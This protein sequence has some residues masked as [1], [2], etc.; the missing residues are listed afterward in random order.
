MFTCSFDSYYDGLRTKNKV[1]GKYTL[2]GRF[3]NVSET[4]VYD[5]GETYLK[6]TPFYIKNLDSRS[7]TV[8]TNVDDFS[9]GAIK[10]VVLNK[11]PTETM[12]SQLVGTWEITDSWRYGNETYTFNS[13]GSYSKVDSYSNTSNGYYMILEGNLYLFSDGR[14]SVRIE[15]G[16]LYIGSYSYRK[17]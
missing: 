2:N 16:L 10:R 15:G 5:N 12:E 7:M 4:I 11:K 3:L 8:Y 9:Y 1:E 14:Y 13:N 17:R 6:E